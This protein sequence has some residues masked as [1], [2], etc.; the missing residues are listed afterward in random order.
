AYA[1]KARCA[2]PPF[3]GA[4]RS[5]I[6]EAYKN[7]R[8][9]YSDIQYLWLGRG[10]NEHV[11]PYIHGGITPSGNLFGGTV[12]YPVLSGVLMWIGALGART[13]AA[14]LLHSALILA[15]FGLLTAWLLGRMRGWRALW[16]AASPA[17]V[18]FAF[19][20][21]D[22]PA[23]ATVVGAVFVMTR[24]RRTMRTRGM[25]AAVLLAI[26]ACLKLYPGLFV[27]PIA[28]AVL[29]GD[30][31]GRHVPDAARADTHPARTTAD[32]RGAAAVLAAAIATVAAVNL[33]F[34]LLGF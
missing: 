27:L 19:H 14:F 26:G 4:G 15:P 7:T 2:G 20:N 12:E 13:D 34:A 32:V 16:W 21:W 33:P 8:V 11:F 24:M 18:L 30:G 31:G 5:L 22:L 28:L 3:T 25:L 9:C 10:I 1:N 17:L 29:C 6:F 23:V